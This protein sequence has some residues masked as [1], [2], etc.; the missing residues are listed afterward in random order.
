[1]RYISRL[2]KTLAL[3]ISVVSFF[4]CVK[5]AEHPYDI[6]E[7]GYRDIMFTLSSEGEVETRSQIS[8]FLVDQIK[9]V[10]M[11]VYDSDGNLYQSLIAGTLSELKC[12]FKVNDMYKVYM[13]ANVSA[14]GTPPIK[15]SDFVR[16]T[17]NS[18]IAY[19]A[20]NGIPMCGSVSVN[21]SNMSSGTIPVVLT[22]LF[23]RV[24]LKVDFSGLS[25]SDVTITSASVKQVSKVVAPFNGP[26]KA[27]SVADGDYTTAIDVNLLNAGSNVTFYVPENS[28]GVLMPGNVDPALKEPANLDLPQVCTYVEFK[29]RHSGTYEGLPISSDNVTYRFYLGKDSTTDFSVERNQSLVITL[30]M[31]DSGMYTDSWKASY[32]TELPV[33]SYELEVTPASVDIYVGESMPLTAVL[34]KLVNG[35]RTTNETVT[36]SAV[37]SSSD[38]GTATV[39][40]GTVV[41]AAPGDCFVT[42]S[43]MGCSADASV[44]VENKITYTYR[45]YIVGYDSI[46]TG[47]DT[48]PYKV[49]YYT[50]TYTAGVLTESG[51]TAVQFTG[52]VTW[53]VSSGT[54]YGTISSSG[55]F[56]G[57]AEGKARIKAVVVINGTSCETYKDID[58]QKPS[59][60][61]PDTG[62]EDGGDVDYD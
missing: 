29:A 32:G 59:E 52:P 42:A 5:E 15:E 8:S 55:V 58:V 45:P 18:S 33:V 49:Y 36:S 40:K 10:S 3:L 9:S 28:Q 20:S 22:R 31:T 6:P 44:H 62:W 56:H 39:N 24:S 43:Y 16:R 50:D 13:L 4:G 53:S 34:Y 11:F 1:M 21:D 54:S 26:Y 61:G 23:A 38:S 19:A 37:W 41:A 30:R 46:V 12:R 35:V 14:I 57:T 51:T 27:T 48:Q 17:Y 25:E 2:W 47:E 60:P 7:D